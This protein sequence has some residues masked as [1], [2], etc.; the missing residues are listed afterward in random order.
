[1]EPDVPGGL[2]LA[3]WFDHLGSIEQVVG[4]DGASQGA[5]SYDAWGQSRT[6]NW[7]SGSASRPAGLRRGYGGHE[8]LD[9]LGLVHMNG[10]L[11]D[12]ELGQFILPDPIVADPFHPQAWNRYAYTYGDNAVEKC[13]LD[14]R[15]HTIRH[16]GADRSIHDYGPVRAVRHWPS[17]RSGSNRP[18]TE[19]SIRSGETIISSDQT[20]A[21]RG[22]VIVHSSRR[23][24]RRAEGAL[25]RGTAAGGPP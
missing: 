7:E 19:S 14:G 4:E 25:T 22:Q 3:P 20:Y 9:E 11:Y 8:M 2:G 13:N 10:R 6:A 17:R 12:P 16:A 1:M 18:W 23:E 15:D 5:W 24:G 21:H